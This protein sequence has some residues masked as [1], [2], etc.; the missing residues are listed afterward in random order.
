VLRD[1]DRPVLRLHLTDVEAG[2][3]RLRE[4]LA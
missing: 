2:L 3:T 4:L 1:H